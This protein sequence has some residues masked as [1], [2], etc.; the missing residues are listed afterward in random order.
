MEKIFI[1]TQSN[2]TLFDSY[3]KK[4]ISFF[5]FQAEQGSY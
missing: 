4:L 1:R 3:Q 2:L 5:R